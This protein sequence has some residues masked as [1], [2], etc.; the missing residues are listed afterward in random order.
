[1]TDVNTTKFYQFLASFN[2]EGGWANVADKKYGNEDGLMSA[3]EWDSL[4]ENHETAL[5][6]Q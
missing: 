1:M 5:L 4:L 2:K 6:N 3:E